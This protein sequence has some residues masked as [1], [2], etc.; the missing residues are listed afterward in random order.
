M[1]PLS[2]SDCGTTHGAARHPGL[3][4]GL[5]PADTTVFGELFVSS[6]AQYPASDRVTKAV[7]RSH[8]PTVAPSPPASQHK[9]R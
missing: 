7:E 1:R 6:Y 4:D 9:I 8:P 2:G 3:R 5:R